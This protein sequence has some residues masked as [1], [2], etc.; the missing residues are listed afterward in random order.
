MEGVSDWPQTH[1]YQEAPRKTITEYKQ[2]P[3]WNPWQCGGNIQWANPLNTASSPFFIFI[4]LFGPIVGIKIWIM[5]L[6]FLGLLGMYLVSKIYGLKSWYAY[7]PPIIFF[8]SGTFAAY[9]YSGQTHLL[10][11]SIIPWV[12]YFY[13]RSLENHKWLFMTSISIAMLWLTPTLYIFIFTLMILGLTV[14]LDLASVKDKNK[15]KDILLITA[16]TFLLAF[17]IMSIKLIPSLNIYFDN[18]RVIKQTDGISMIDFTKNL[19]NN[20]NSQDHETYSYAGPLITT[21][22]FLSL[23][24]NWRKYWKLS[25]LSLVFLMIALGDK[26]PIN[27]L[28]LLQNLPIFNSLHVSTRYRIPF[29]FFASVLSGITLQ[30]FSSFNINLNKISVKNKTIRAIIFILTLYAITNM[31]FTNSLIMNK[32]FSVEPVEKQEGIFEQTINNYEGAGYN[33]VNKEWIAINKNKGSVACYETTVIPSAQIK[34]GIWYY[35]T[36]AAIPKSYEFYLGEAFLLE[37]KSE[38]NIIYWSPNKIVVETNPKE[39]FLVINQNFYKGWKVYNEKNNLNNKIYNIEG[40]IGT[41]ISKNYSSKITFY[42][43]PKIFII[44]SV[45]TIL[46]MIII[47]KYNRNKWK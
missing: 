13:K 23:I 7:I 41:K 15:V 12:F 17:L 21:L 46:S 11:M 47:I 43:L 40:L 2:V 31:L 30:K 29:L 33:K 22:I 27:I 39:D 4:I 45:I 38:T 5:V 36:G 6:L 44:S 26:S 20:T 32:T 24:L 19:L 16:T 1:F 35:H 25:I 9:V 10:G 18:P 14:L 3:L 37:N 34:G 28:G 42:Y 8:F